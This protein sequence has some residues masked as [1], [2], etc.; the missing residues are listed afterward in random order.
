MHDISSDAVAP[1]SPNRRHHG[2]LDARA[3]Q[4]R[5][6]RQFLATMLPRDYGEHRQPRITTSQAQQL[7]IGSREILSGDAHSA[8]QKSAL[9]IRQRCITPEITGATRL[10]RGASG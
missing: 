4:Q 1:P 3:E 5:K 10:Y 6:L 7:I 2:V 9:T 8:P